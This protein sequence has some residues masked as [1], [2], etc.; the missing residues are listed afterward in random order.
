[1]VI[2]SKILQLTIAV[3]H[4]RVQSFS[5][6]CIRQYSHEALT[7]VLVKFGPTD[8]ELGNDQGHVSF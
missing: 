6:P 5:E 7:K 1:M 8:I 4:N 2:S 3:I